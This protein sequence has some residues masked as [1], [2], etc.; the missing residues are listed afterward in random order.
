MAQA[1][2]D[3]ASKRAATT[4]TQPTF[5]DTFEHM[6]NVYVC[7]CVCAKQEIQQNDMYELMIINAYKDL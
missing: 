7:V 1:K 3:Q 6:S 4:K 5:W 2:S